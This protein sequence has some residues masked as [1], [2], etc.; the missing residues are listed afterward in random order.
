MPPSSIPS[1][2]KSLRVALLP[3]L[4]AA[5]CGTA[6]AQQEAPPSINIPYEFDSG[7]FENTSST[8][9]VVLSFPVVMDGAEWI[10]LYF[11]DLTLSGN[12]ADDTGSILRLT[13]LK[14][15]SIQELNARHVT[16]WQNSSAY[17]NGD[18]VLVEVL[19]QP[20]S[21]W[22]RVAMRS[23]DMGLIYT[24]EE[25]ICGSTDDRVL[26]TDPRVARILPVGCTGW[27]I[28]D[29]GQCF[30][31][32]GHCSGGV[33]V[34]Q[35]N[36]PLSNNSGSLN[37]PPASEQYSADSSSMQTNGGQGVGNDWAY[38]G[39]F[40]NSN[41]GLTPGQA[42]GSVFALVNPP[43]AS[44]TTIR[45]TGHGV[46]GGNR[47][48]VQQ[49][50]AGPAVSLSSSSLSYVTDTQ[51]GNSGSPVIWDQ[52]DQAVGIHTHGGCGSTGGSNNGTASTNSG[53][54][55]ALADP[56]GIC[57]G[58][59][60]F[61]QPYPE[62]T[63]AGNPVAVQV[64]LLSAGSGV[65]L[66]Y[67]LS[68]GSFQTQ[69]MVAQGG[70]FYEGTIP[71]PACGDD[72]DF[73]FSYVDDTCGLIFEPSEA[74]TT[75]F[76][77]NVGTNQ[78]VFADNFEAN[79]GWTTTVN[80]ATSGAWERGVPVNDPNYAFDPMSDSDGSGSC[81]LTEN[82]LGDTDVDGGS[83]SLISPV[84]DLTQVDSFVSYDYFLRKSNGGIG[85]DKMQVHA[86]NGSGAWLVVANHSS[87]G[88]LTWRPHTITA[89][90][91]ASSGITN[92]NDVQLRFT[93]DDV[94][95]ASVNEGG[96]DNF[97]LGRVSCG[98]GPGSNYCSPSP[99][100]AAIEASGSASVSA[101]DLT[102]TASAVPQNVFGIFFYGDL[103]NSVPLGNG[104]L[105]ISG[106]NGIFRLGPPQ[107]TGALG[108]VSRL[109]DLTNPPLPA[110]QV[111][112]GSTW[113]YQFWFRDG[114][115]SDLTD[116]VEVLFL[117]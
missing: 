52:I 64:E 46:D 3:G 29:C 28:D 5:I 78:A 55:A 73:Y 1:K 89:A 11:E 103:Q 49:T 85:N 30:L 84:L 102:L 22:N 19:A 42:S 15:G 7:W 39:A 32:A 24:P 38:F 58:G 109:I 65:T 14:D 50:H 27:L 81:Y 114:A 17:F 62:L 108:H 98:D 59:S 92:T 101:N 21:G 100:G 115:T 90:T 31:T 57:A 44:G 88:G 79:N 45:V 10:R 26:S 20:G 34:L 63:P 77:M 91:F 33:S 18:T 82:G 105:C 93:V 35:F 54:Q 43:S 51:G 36:V 13:A 87:N 48:Q 71:A 86:R 107:N 80:G 94:G 4:L 69:A 40:A 96:L 113:N 60:F 83:V 41:T 56:Q 47:N 67:R 97:F 75:F 61:P 99:S 110:G 25:S 2:V 112:A 117:P 8:P 70:G 68:P 76:S 6:G 106:T 72:P 9:E 66:H 111:T 95:T 23:I 53:L 116:A 16:Q 12:L 104:L 74:P 37:H